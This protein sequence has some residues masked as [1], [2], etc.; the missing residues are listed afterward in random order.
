ME[1]RSPEERVGRRK[2]VVREVAREEL[3]RRK[4]SS[5]GGRCGEMCVV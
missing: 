3:V 2:E 4:V 5:G 1:G